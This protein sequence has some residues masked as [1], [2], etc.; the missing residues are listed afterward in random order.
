MKEKLK[1]PVDEFTSPD[2]VT[3]G[4]ETPYAEIATLMRENDFR[5]L[6]VVEEGRLVGII[7]ERNLK[8][9]HEFEGV[10]RLLARDILTADPF[11]VRDTT[12]LEEV[13]FE[14]SSRK[15][16]SAVVLGEGGEIS[17]IFTS[18]DALNALVEVIRGDLD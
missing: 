14:M 13:A 8:L 4:P 16:G 11:T 2:P 5:H 15:I 12:S 7:S 9:P 1:I 3:V 6:P 18:T 10:D 17:G